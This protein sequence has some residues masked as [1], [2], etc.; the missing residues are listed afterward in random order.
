MSRLITLILATL[1]VAVMIGSG[2]C[3]IG[4]AIQGDIAATVAMAVL[5]IVDFM[6][7]DAC[8]TDYME[9]SEEQRQRRQGR[10][11]AFVRATS[12]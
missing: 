9:W 10:F 8:V 6:A 5:A 1:F 12:R 11:A 7:A 4:A 3:A 2:C